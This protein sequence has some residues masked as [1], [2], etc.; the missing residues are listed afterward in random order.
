LK[1]EKGFGMLDKGKRLERR[2]RKKFEIFIVNTR[3]NVN[4]KTPPP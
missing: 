3:K 2:K 4:A 1:F